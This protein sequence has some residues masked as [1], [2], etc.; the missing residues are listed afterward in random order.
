MESIGCRIGR[1]HPLIGS[2]IGLSVRLIDEMLAI[3]YMLP[4]TDNLL[5]FLFEFQP[6]NHTKSKVTYV[7]HA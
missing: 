3:T 6:I 4:P 2:Q 1:P 7:K 5:Y